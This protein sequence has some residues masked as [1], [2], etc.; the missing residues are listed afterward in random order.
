MSAVK[1]SFSIRNEKELKSPEH[2]ERHLQG[3]RIIADLYPDA[4]IS[5][6][7]IMNISGHRNEESITHYNTRP[8][9]SH[10]RQCSDVLSAACSLQSASNPSI[11]DGSFVSP[12]D[13]L[14]LS[15]VPASNKPTTKPFQQQQLQ[16]NSPFQILGSSGM[17]NSC[18]IQNDP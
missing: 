3:S 9:P 17:F 13:P 6:R 16:Q 15:V 1:F 4:Q 8:A 7:H 18:Q 5:S 12:P 2:D 14:Q 11:Q 10:L